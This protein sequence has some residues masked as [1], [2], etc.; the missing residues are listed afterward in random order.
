MVDK[1]VRGVKVELQ[2]EVPK[3]CIESGS[4]LASRCMLGS[5]MRGC[6]APVGSRAKLPASLFPAGGG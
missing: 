4:S 6:L 3:T 2:E 5:P 1:V